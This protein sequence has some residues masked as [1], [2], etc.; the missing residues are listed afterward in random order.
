MPCALGQVL[1][2]GAEGAQNGPCRW[3]WDIQAGGREGEQE[4]GALVLPPGGECPA[5]TIFRDWGTE[6]A[7]TCLLS[8]GS[9]V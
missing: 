2:M 3:H 1:E 8:D 7:A 9:Y 4:T 5:D 6:S